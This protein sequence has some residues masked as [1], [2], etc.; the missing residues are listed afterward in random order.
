MRTRTRTAL[1]ID[2]GSSRI[3]AALIEKTDQSVKILAAATRTLSGDDAKPRAQRPAKVLS[4]VLRKLGRH[5]RAR[6]VRAAVATPAASMIMRLMDLPK[7]MPTNIGEFVEG[8]LKQYVAM[9]GRQMTSDFCGI[10]S[11]SGSRKRLL[12]VATDSGEVVETLKICRAAGV[13]V[14]SVEPAALAYARAVLAGERDLRRDHAMLAM[15]TR[16]T[17]I[18]CVFCNG[19]LDFVRIRDV[20]AGANTSES[21]RTWLAEELNAV[22]RYSRTDASNTGLRWQARLVIQDAAF[23]RDE[24]ADLPGLEPSVR[25]LTVVDC[26]DPIRTFDAMEEVA[27]SSLTA[28][29]AALK[30]LEVEG[31]DLR[32]D[33]TPSEVIQARSSSRRGLIAANVAAAALVAIFLLVQLL[34]GT[35]ERM[36]RRIERN[37]VEQQLCTMP[38]VATENQYLD[39]EILQ[40]TRELNGLKPARERREVEWPDVLHSI[41]QAAPAGL[42]VTHMTCSDR[43]NL[44]LKGLAL[45]HNEAKAF[46]QNLDGKPVFESVQLTRVQRVD[47]AAGVM[48]YEINCVLRPLNQKGQSGQRS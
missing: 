2:I 29:G 15:L 6:G 11:G 3:S 23:S 17:L 20:P 33:L 46:T 28:V 42:G 4:Q 1:G 13:S 7:Q 37:R 40:A 5:A 32:I 45:S 25:A 27:A 38:A 47:S 39:A 44:L 12:A 9:S 43:R 14:E 30:L 16:D 41:G 34:S 36:N 35:T 18:L 8:E 31:D 48:E 21:V 26:H 24:L 19:I 10:G 22:L